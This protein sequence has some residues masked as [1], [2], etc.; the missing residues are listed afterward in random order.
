MAAN[1]PSG[2]TA[3]A[4]LFVAA[5][6]LG[7]RSLCQAADITGVEM[8]LPAKERP[9]QVTYFRAPGNAVRPSA[10]ILHGAGGLARGR[11]R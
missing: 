7:L 11:G 3:R 10:L 2:L 8:T 9:V 5:I 6:F 4:A 1:S